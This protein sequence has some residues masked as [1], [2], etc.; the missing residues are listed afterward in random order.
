M[1]INA[2][3]IAAAA[4]QAATATTSSQQQQTSNTQSSSSISRNS[5]CSRKNKESY[6]DMSTVSS[7]TLT[8]NSDSD[9]ATL[10]V[11]EKLEKLVD[12]SSSTTEIDPSSKSASNFDL[13]NRFENDCFRFFS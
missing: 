9:P 10:T 12:S 13:V 8:N 6:R 7:S 3:A 1:T 5:K 4:A 11:Q 2:T